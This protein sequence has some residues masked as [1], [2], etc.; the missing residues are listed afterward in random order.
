MNNPHII[1]VSPRSAFGLNFIKENISNNYEEIDERLFDNYLE[2]SERKNSKSSSF[3]NGNNSSLDVSP[4][5]SEEES[6]SSHQCKQSV[7][8]SGRKMMKSTNNNQKKRETKS[9]YLLLFL[10]DKAI[11]WGRGVYVTNDFIC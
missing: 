8:G 11:V 6:D 10:G 5:L 7:I 2:I 9:M 1:S 3:E 4:C